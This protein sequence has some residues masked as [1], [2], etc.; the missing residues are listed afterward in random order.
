[1]VKQQNTKT[2]MKTNSLLIASLV[3]LASAV[4]SNAIYT[5]R[6]RLTNIR[7]IF[8]TWLTGFV[9]KTCSK[10]ANIHVSSRSSL[11]LAPTLVVAAM[12]ILSVPAQLTY[13]TPGDLDLY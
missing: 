5:R 7:L 3:L 1:M 9:R 6:D 2:S 4:K 11:R 13:A 8:V 10:T 12:F